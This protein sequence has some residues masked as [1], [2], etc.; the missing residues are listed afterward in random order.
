MNSKSVIKSAVLAA[1]A[2]L[3]VYTNSAFADFGPKIPR[4]DITRWT[5]QDYASPSIGGRVHYAAKFTLK[6]TETP[7]GR[8]WSRLILFSQAGHIGIE[9]SLFQLNKAQGIQCASGC[10]ITIQFDDKPPVQVKGRIPDVQSGLRLSPANDIIEQMKAADKTV[11][12]IPFSDNQPVDFSF[13]TSGL[14]WP[15]D[16]K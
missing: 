16:D 12:T 7:I 8:F 10:D 1:T 11:I 5:Y 3:S 14:E 2:I 9:F 6:E 15:R 13:D 4:Y